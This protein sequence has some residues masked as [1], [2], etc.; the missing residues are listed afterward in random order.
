MLI[1]PAG[2]D[3][4]TYLIQDIHSI[5]T[6]A[7]INFTKEALLG[8]TTTIVDTIICPKDSSA[9]DLL[10]KYKNNFKETKF[11]CDIIIRIGFMEIQESHLNEIEQLTKQHGINSFLLELR[12]IEKCI[13]LVTSTNCPVIFSSINEMNIIERISEIRRQIPPIHITVCCTSNSLLSE[14][15]HNQQCG[16]GLLPLLTNG[17]IKLISSDHSNID[18]N[19]KSNSLQTIRQR[20]ITTWKAGVPTGWLDASTFVSLTSSNA[21]YYLGLYPNKGS[22]YPGSDADLIC[23]PY[24]NITNCTIQHPSLVIHHGKLIVYNGNLIQDISNNNNDLKIIPCNHL[25]E[26]QSNQPLGMLQTGKLFPSTIYDLVNAFERLRK[27]NQIP[28][29]R[30]P[31][32]MNNLSGE[33][34][35]ISKITNNHDNNNNGNNSEQT[36]DGNPQNL[37]TTPVNIRTIRGNRDLH[38]S[39]FSL[40]G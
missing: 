21:A 9:V 37:M 12:S 35:T 34:T 7:Y 6:E 40:S 39:G 31:W 14:I 38:A 32:T 23:W 17:D 29:I 33:L 11:W 24:D 2:I 1:M 18:T 5:D 28:V 15:T 30:E 25:N 27:T 19:G 16:N 4:S 13:V 8:G 22:L 26:I 3:M 36:K 20:L 10:I